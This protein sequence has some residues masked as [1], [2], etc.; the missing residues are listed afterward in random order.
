[1][2]NVFSGPMNSAKQREIMN[3]VFAAA[4]TGGLLSISDLYTKLSYSH[5]CSYKSVAGSV[6]ILE[7]RWGLIAKKGHR[8]GYRHLLPTPR[9]Y[10]VYRSTIPV[11][12]IS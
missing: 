6:S 4:D 8:N 10:A 9:A 11:L 5:E 2:T 3:H 7:K 12:E 1:M